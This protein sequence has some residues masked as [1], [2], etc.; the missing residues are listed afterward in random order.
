MVLKKRM[1][2]IRDGKKIGASA[3]GEVFLNESVV[4][5]LDFFLRGDFFL[6]EKF[7]G[8]FFCKRSAFFSA[9]EKKA[10]SVWER[11]IQTSSVF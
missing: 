10:L 7:L 3:G 9:A 5:S 1:Q 4:E 11:N 8:A 6:L 2:K